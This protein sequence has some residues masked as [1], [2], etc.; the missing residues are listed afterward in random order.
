MN[1]YPQRLADRRDTIPYYKGKQPKR[2]QPKSPFYISEQKKTFSLYLRK[3]PTPQETALWNKLKSRQLGVT[4]TR[5]KVILG[6]I[7]D[8]YCHQLKLVI[9]LDGHNKAEDALRDA[10]FNKVGLYVLRYPNSVVDTNIS[11]ITH[12]ISKRIKDGRF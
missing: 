11:I 12:R 10:A 7:A 5:Q 8:F 4:F 2:Y 1:C 3:N 9:E 6:F